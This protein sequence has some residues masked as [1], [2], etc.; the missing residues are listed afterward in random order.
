MAE[1]SGT[2]LAGYKAQLATTADVLR[3]R[4]RPSP[5]PTTPALQRHHGERRRVPLRPRHPRQGAPSADFVGI[6]FPDGTTTGDA[7]NIKLRF[8]PS[9][10]QMAADGHALSGRRRAGS[11][12][13]AG[14]TA[15]AGP[16]GGRGMRLINRRPDRLTV[17][18]LAALPFGWRSRLRAS[19]SAAR[20]AANPADKL[21]PSLGADRRAPRSRWSPSRTSAPARSCSG[22]TP[23]RASPRLALGARHR[24]RARARRSASSIG[25]LPLRPRRA[26]ALRRGRSR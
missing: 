9:F 3:P 24:R 18:V 15:T 25:F 16:A 21:L 10:M 11:A 26:R 1:A 5:S 8:D 7:N 20:L 4:P 2:D 23:R 14:Q 17:A 6:D 13:A 22:S 19:R 12:D